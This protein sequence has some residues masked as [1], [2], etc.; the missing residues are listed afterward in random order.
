MALKTNKEREQDAIEFL[1][2]FMRGLPEEERAI[3]IYAEEATVQVDENG[4]KINSGFWPKPYKD[5]KYIPSESNDY[6]CISSAIKTPNPKTGEMRYWRS[7]HGFG[8]GMGFFID[9]IGT[10]KGSKGNM[11]LEYI[12]SILPPTAVVETS[13]NNYQCWYFFPE[14]V[15]ERQYFKNFLYSFVAEVLEGAGG[16]ATIKDAVRVGRMPYGINNKRNSDGSFKYLDEKGKPFRVG[17]V[18]ADY[19]RRYSI[20]D[21]ADAFKFT[22]ADH[23]IKRDVDIDPAEY[24][25]DKIWFS[26]AKRIVDSLAMGEGTNGQA[27]ENQS[28]KIRIRCPWGHEHTNGDPYGAYFRGPIPG[29]EVEFVFGCAHDTCRKIHRRTWS[30]FVD[31]I[32]MSRIEVQLERANRE[33]LGVPDIEA[34]SLIDA[35]AK[36]GR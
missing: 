28:R 14:P 12:E 19:S 29:A 33:W 21:I 25:Y 35:K 7:E 30:A 15:S 34:C 13:P 3:V 24:L 32:V 4:K 8:H 23:R 31:A 20:E 5:G 11:T 10:G 6:I 22:I 26:L 18:A 2:E 16:D 36:V 9:D 17:I 27:V 1:R